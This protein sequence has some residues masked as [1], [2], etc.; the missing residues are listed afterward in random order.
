MDIVTCVSHSNFNSKHHDKCQ[1][2]FTFI[3]LHMRSM[4]ETI[5]DAWACWSGWK[6]WSKFLRIPLF[7]S[8][9][10][11]PNENCQRFQIWEFQNPPQWKLS[12]IPNPRVSEYPPNENCQRFQIRQ[13]QN[14]PPMKIVRESK[15][16]SFQNTPPQWKIVRESQIREFQNTT[17]PPQNENC[18]SSNPRVSEYPPPPS[19]KTLDFKL[20][21]AFCTFLGTISML[22]M[23]NMTL[24]GHNRVFPVIHKVGI[25]VLL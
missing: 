18:Q 7:C 11:T 8:T 6:F 23:S 12:E 16:N 19:E 9:E 24:P 2:A 1:F 4:W 5:C 17:T 3:S 14:T 13:F 15:S 20:H 10:Y 22:V 25:F 21:F